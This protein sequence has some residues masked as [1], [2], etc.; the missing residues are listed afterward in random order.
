[1]G[2]ISKT[3]FTRFPLT[4]TQSEEGEESVARKPKNVQSERPTGSSRPLIHTLPM[5]RP[6]R[7]ADFSLRR[8]H[9][10]TLFFPFSLQ[11]GREMG[12]QPPQQ[13][14]SFILQ[15]SPWAAGLVGALRS[16]NVSRRNRFVLLPPLY[17]KG[18]LGVQ[19]KANPSKPQDGDPEIHSMPLTLEVSTDGWMVLRNFNFTLS[20]L[21]IICSNNYF[22]NLRR[23]MFD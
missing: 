5:V 7:M 16:L 18:R 14:S 20:L 13:K 19:L 2:H 6:Q 17:I 1:M 9:V 23:H 11:G 10:K 3:L 21:R 12:C 22:V 15:V 4:R 8:G